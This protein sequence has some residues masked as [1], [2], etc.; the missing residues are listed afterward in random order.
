MDGMHD[1]FCTEC[2]LFYDSREPHVCLDLLGNPVVKAVLLSV[3]PRRYL[4]N[5]NSK[6]SHNIPA[7]KPVTRNFLNF[8][9]M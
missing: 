6:V 7:N 9:R 3:M 5:L 4:Y 2:G 1:E 8:V